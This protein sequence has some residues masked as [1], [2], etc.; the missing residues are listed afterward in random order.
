M[1]K[2]T[3]TMKAI[4]DVA[5][6]GEWHDFYDFARVGAQGQSTSSMVKSGMLSVR[7]VSRGGPKEWVITDIGRLSLISGLRP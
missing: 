2:L 4:L 7:E 1:A 3:P 6:D 5:S